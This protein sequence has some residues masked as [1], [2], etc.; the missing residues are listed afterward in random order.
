LTFSVDEPHPLMKGKAARLI[1]E[2]AIV[3]ELFIS[4]HLL[5]LGET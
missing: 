2:I 1:S 3:V 5:R 4:E